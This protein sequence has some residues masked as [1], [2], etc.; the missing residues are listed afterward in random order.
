MQNGR[1]TEK[2]SNAS[3]KTAITLL[4]VNVDRST[5]KTRKN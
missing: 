5:I 4:D 2:S 1:E 3:I